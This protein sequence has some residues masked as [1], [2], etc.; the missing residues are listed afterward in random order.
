MSSSVVGPSI[1]LKMWQ[2][3]AAYLVSIYLSSGACVT[4]KPL[5]P[6]SANAGLELGFTLSPSDDRM[7]R[8]I[9]KESSRREVGR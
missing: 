4:A 3:F 2:L 9:L 5:S 6:L 7:T 8:Y 1:G